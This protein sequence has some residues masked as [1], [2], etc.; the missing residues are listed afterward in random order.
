MECIC[1]NTDKSIIA[2]YLN[3]IP[4][5]ARRDTGASFIIKEDKDIR[6]ISSNKK[7]YG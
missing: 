3:N 4:L 5:I 7:R 1:V 2:E 6:T